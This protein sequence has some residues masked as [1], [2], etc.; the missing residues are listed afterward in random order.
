MEHINYRTQFKKSLKND[1][2]LISAY[3]NFENNQR[4]DLII[5]ANQSLNLKEDTLYDCK[6]NKMKEPKIGYVVF[7]AKEAKDSLQIRIVNNFD[8][9][10]ENNG[11][12]LF[13]FIS[14]KGDSAIDKISDK[15]IKYPFVTDPMIIKQLSE[16]FK[17]TCISQYKSYKKSVIKS[18]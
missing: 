17:K 10:L 11:I 13:N 14:E 5:I 8:V 15:I 16:D 1:K 7:S 2:I 6:L 9:V 4:K 3:V 12:T 18:N